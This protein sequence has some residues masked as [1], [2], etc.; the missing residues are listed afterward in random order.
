LLF[1]EF[2]WLAVVDGVVAV[3][4]YALDVAVEGLPFEGTPAALI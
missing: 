3:D 2:Q 4:P 1:A